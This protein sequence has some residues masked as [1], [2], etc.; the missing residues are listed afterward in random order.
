MWIAV[1]AGIVVVAFI[2]WRLFLA[3]RGRGPGR[4]VDSGHPHATDVDPHSDY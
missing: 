1:L 2:A 4:P 3:V